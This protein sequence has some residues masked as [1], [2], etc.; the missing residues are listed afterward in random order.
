MGYIG[1][2]VTCPAC[3]TTGRIGRNGERFDQD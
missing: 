3:G 1:A 2:P